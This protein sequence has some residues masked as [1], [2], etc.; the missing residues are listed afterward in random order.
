MSA[1]LKIR[2]ESLNF[3]QALL[4]LLLHERRRHEQDIEKIDKDIERLRKKGV[5][6]DGF[7][8]HEL[9]AWVEA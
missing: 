4:W 5:S 7:A 1:D 9:D 8:D 3:H 6:V 2:L